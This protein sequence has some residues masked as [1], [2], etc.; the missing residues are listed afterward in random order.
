MREKCIG[1]ATTIEIERSSCYHT[2]F[3]AVNEIF[4]KGENT[5]FHLDYYIASYWFE[6]SLKLAMG[7]FAS[8]I[9]VFNMT[10]LL[11]FWDIPNAISLNGKLKK[12]KQLFVSS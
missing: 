6:C 10:T 4:F 12:W 1:I 11:S 8:G 5:K 9:G 2:G 3:A 7:T